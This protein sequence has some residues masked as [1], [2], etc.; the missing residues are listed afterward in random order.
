MATNINDITAS[1]SPIPQAGK[2][3]VDIQDTFVSK[4][5]AFQDKL[6]SD[7]VD[8]LNGLVT[9]LNTFKNQV[10]TVGDE[11]NQI[12]ND[13]EDAKD[14]A[15]EW[16]TKTTGTVDGTDY[17]AKQYALNASA[18]ASSASSSASS[19][20]SSAQDA[21]DFVNGLTVTSTSV[22]KDGVTFNKYTHPTYMG[23]DF[24][25]DTGTLTGATVISDLDMNVT[26]D[27][28][29]HVTDANAVVST[30]NLTA[31]D[32]GALALSGGNITGTVEFQDNKICA[33]GNSADMEIFHSGS[34]GY[35]D[36]NTG[37]LIIRDSTTTRYTFDDNG[38]FTATGNITAYSDERVKTNIEVIPDALNKVKSISGYTFDRTDVEC[39][40]QTGVIAQELLKVLPEAVRYDEVEDKYSVNYGATIGLLIEAI[41]ELEKRIK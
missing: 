33:F 18:S 5:E 10:N 30:R 26:T 17:S 7:T 25:I 40:R 37:N 8:E 41:K 16:A 32:V 23:D 38:D 39:D 1:V 13:S 11:L 36:I 28:Q 9:N 24:S 14:L 21:L 29:G 3:G 19:A 34:H 22:S 12:I 20:S 2:R 6:T 15:E 27:T 4:Q 31:S 35:I